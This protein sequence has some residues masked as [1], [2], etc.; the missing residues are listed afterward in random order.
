VQELKKWEPEECE[1]YKANYKAATKGNYDIYVVFI[2]RALSLLTSNGLLGFICP[3]KFLTKD[4]ARILRKCISQNK[5][6]RELISF[7]ANQV[8]RGV[9]TYTC[10]VVL[11]KHRNESKVRA[12]NIQKIDDAVSTCGHIATSDSPL[13]GKANVLFAGHPKSELP[14]SFSQ[15]T[16]AVMFESLPRLKELSQIFVGVQTNADDVYYLTPVK[17]NRHT[18]TVRVFCS[19]SHKEYDIEAEILRDLLQGANVSSYEL[20][21]PIAKIIFPFRANIKQRFVPIT[22]AELRRRF[23][24]AAQFFADRPIRE[25]LQ[26]RAGG[27]LRASEEFWDFI[28]RK[29]LAKQSL[30]KICVPRLAERVIAALDDEG[31]YCLDNVD[32]CGVI[33]THKNLDITY[34]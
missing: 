6:L 3:N 11:Q 17:N 5:N 25:R 14:W 30:K 24:L 23:P 28:Y 22:A 1:F 4:Y 29:N 21:E 15:S 2:E 10:I 32:V 12:V 26:S 31:R 19:C 20:R 9:T 8:F 27:K 34:V 13:P 16:L 7:G 18:N 33:P